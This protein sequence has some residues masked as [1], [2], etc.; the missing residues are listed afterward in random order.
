MTNKID[1][2]LM[3][4]AFEA[5]R[6]AAPIVVVIDVLRASTTIVTALANGAKSVI[7][8]AGVEEARATFAKM[9]ADSTLL[10]GERGGYRVSGFHLGNSPLDY[11]EDVVGGKTLVFASTNGSKMLVRARE[12][13]TDFGAGGTVLMA[14]FTNVSATLKRL[15]ESGQDCILACS[16]RE[17]DFSLEDTLCAGMIVEGLTRTGP[18]EATDAA[19]TAR[20]LYQNHADDLEG[21]VRDSFHGRYL[22]KEGMQRDLPVCAETDRHGVVVVWGDGGLIVEDLYTAG[23]VHN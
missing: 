10:C 21:A 18:F 3:P 1:V 2:A 8:A 13:V 22:A 12:V 16:G 9:P 19:K 4:T 5:G 20:I 15:R 14:G 17:G 6:Y 7:P 23:S 11:T